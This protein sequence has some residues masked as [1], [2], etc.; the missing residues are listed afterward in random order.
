MTE[1]E[2]TPL[3]KI[4]FNKKATE[5][6]RKEIER[7]QSLWNLAERLAKPL[8]ED[9]KSEIRNDVI[10]NCRANGFMPEDSII[11]I[12]VQARIDMEMKKRTALEYQSRTGFKNELTPPQQQNLE[13]RTREDAE[14]GLQ[15][16]NEMYPIAQ[17]LRN[18]KVFYDIDV[19]DD[20]NKIASYINT[21]NKTI[22]EPL[23]QYGHILITIPILDLSEPQKRDTWLTRLRQGEIL[24]DRWFSTVRDILTRLSK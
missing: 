14:Y 18:A 17:K 21:F 1:D 22:S 15:I 6:R 4:G 5:E 11:N 13:Q 19:N 16:V 12:E 2:Q 20:M 3:E 23:S 24:S 7:Q 10:E 8:S 9:E